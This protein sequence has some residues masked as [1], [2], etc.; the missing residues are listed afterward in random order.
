[1]LI[2]RLKDFLINILNNSGDGNYPP[3]LQKQ[4]LLWLAGIIALGIILLIAGSYGS[5]ERNQQPKTQIREETESIISNLSMMDQEEKNLAGNL[6]KIL[7]QIEGA[8]QLDVTIRLATS[9]QDL[10]AVN[11]TSGRKTT[12]EKD[13]VGGTRLTTENTDSGQLVLV[14]NGQEEAPVV[15]EARCAQIAG[16]LVVA[17]GAKDPEIKGRL[18]KAVQVALGIEPQKVLI[19]PRSE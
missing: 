8:G 2:Q 17:Q 10:Y 5:Q 12:E 1:M 15:E 4:K 7:T 6:K 3:K 16:V 11:T 18:F 9:R 19:L 13:Q 14:R